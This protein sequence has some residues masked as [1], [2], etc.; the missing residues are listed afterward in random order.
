MERMTYLGSHYFATMV[1]NWSSKDT[2]IVS[3]ASHCRDLTD[4]ITNSETN[5][6]KHYTLH[7]GM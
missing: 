5:S 6:K 2:K 4:L 1:D 3:S 7:G